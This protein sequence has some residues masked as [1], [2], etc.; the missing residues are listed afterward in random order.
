M[1]VHPYTVTQATTLR[2]GMVWYG[3]KYTCLDSF[4][5]L[6]DGETHPSNA[7]NHR[8]SCC[9][10]RSSSLFGF[11]S[12]PPWKWVG[13]QGER[14]RGCRV[15]RCPA[16]MTRTAPV[17]TPLASDRRTAIQ[18]TNP[19]LTAVFLFFNSTISHLMSY[20]SAARMVK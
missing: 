9:S 10:R 11:V 20:T 1:L 19:T 17:S 8:R 15:L 5:V 2:C 7:I 12:H 3:A 13:P 6:F 18:P 14:V 4:S 16:L